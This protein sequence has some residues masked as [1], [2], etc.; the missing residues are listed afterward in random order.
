MWVA[1]GKGN[2]LDPVSYIG[3]GLIS[4]HIAVTIE[5]G[6][7]RQGVKQIYREDPTPQLGMLPTELIRRRR[8][9]ESPVRLG[10]GK[11]AFGIALLPGMA[12]LRVPGGDCPLK[13][14]STIL[15]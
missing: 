13:Q 15:R 12:K 5:V 14:A 10:R 1:L 9:Q 8:G 2:H 4:H 11:R 7:A 6:L 3:V